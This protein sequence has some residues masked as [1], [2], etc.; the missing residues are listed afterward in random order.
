MARSKVQSPKTRLEYYYYCGDASGITGEKILENPPSFN[1]FKQGTA[2]RKF[3]SR[4]RKDYRLFT[5][6]SED[7]SLL[8]V[9]TSSTNTAIRSR[10]EEDQ[11][12]D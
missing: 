12:I 4:G 2:V 8:R 11:D 10:A 1:G 6:A 7:L 3:N 9:R 5:T